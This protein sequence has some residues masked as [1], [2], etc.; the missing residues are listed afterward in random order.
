MNPTTLNELILI[1][2]L[3]TIANIFGAFGVALYV[4]SKRKP[5]DTCKHET[6]MKLSSTQEQLCYV[7]CEVLPWELKPNQPPLVNSSRDKRK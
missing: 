7:C 3:I 2:L 5:V 1:M 6:T 4:K